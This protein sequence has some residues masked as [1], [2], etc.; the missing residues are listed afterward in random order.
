MRLAMAACIDALAGVITTIVE[1]IY[2][3]QR[4][5]EARSAKCSICRKS[6][7]KIPLRCN[8]CTGSRTP[9]ED[10]LAMRQSAT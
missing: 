4:T 2:Q 10:E 7:G 8:V 1:L 9:K 5:K 6:N 3:L